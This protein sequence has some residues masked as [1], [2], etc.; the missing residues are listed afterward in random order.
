M[1]DYVSD[2][3]RIESLIC[4]HCYSLMFYYLTRYYLG[5]P[6]R[7]R[8]KD[9]SMSSI[10]WNHLSLNQWDLLYAHQIFALL[11][12]SLKTWQF[13][14]VISE[15]STVTGELFALKVDGGTKSGGWR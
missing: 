13:S 3:T 2:P 14:A 15:L 12:F 1:V 8:A 7:T 10:L 4:G 11:T 9:M 5:S 6:L